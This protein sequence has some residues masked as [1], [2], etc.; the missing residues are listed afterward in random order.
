MG[1]A[2]PEIGSKGFETKET[3]TEH[4]K[5][6]IQCKNIFFIFIAKDILLQL[7]K[8]AGKKAKISSLIQPKRAV[9]HVFSHVSSQIVM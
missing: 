9:R 3:V 5:Y 4:L 6:F 8:K 1:I 7:D 2:T